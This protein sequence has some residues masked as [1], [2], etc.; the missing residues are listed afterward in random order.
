M[1]NAGP[2]FK[3]ANLV[4]SATLGGTFA[5]A[6]LGAVFTVASPADAQQ[7]TRVSIGVTETIASHN[8]Y[9]DSVSLIV[10]RQHP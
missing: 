5:A 9:A 7:R 4:K 10:P 1:K 6:L 8:P 2:R 3:P